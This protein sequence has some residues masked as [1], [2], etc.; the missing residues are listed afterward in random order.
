MESSRTL[1]SVLVEARALIASEQDWIPRGYAANESGEWRPIGNGDA[2]RFTLL[3]AIVR[4][5]RGSRQLLT[6]ARA[7]FDEVAPT[8]AVK[9]G[10][11]DSELTHAESLAILD[12][13]VAVLGPEER[14]YI[15]KQSGFVTRRAEA[16]D[17][18]SSLFGLVA[19]LRG[20]DSR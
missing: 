3:G 17:K 2:V 19:R 14:E 4:A 20:R 1:R 7:L 12:S 6:A 8:L 16:P 5:G 18:D 10:A 15:P 13:A 11:R 9:L